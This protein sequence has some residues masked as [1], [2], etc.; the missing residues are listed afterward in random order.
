[1]PNLRYK[2]LSKFRP[3]AAAPV[4]AEGAG[5]AAVV[6]AAEPVVLECKDKPTSIKKEANGKLKT[7]IRFQI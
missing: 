1:M 6:A 3:S 4:H 7:F 2:G 5:T